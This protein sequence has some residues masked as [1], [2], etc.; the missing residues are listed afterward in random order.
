[1]RYIRQ[2]CM[3]YHYYILLLHEK[4]FKKHAYKFNKLYEKEYGFL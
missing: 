3:I 1:M 2:L 4:R